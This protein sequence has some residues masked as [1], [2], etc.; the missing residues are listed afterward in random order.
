M[1]CMSERVRCVLNSVCVCV[2]LY[3]YIVYT[4]HDVLCC[5]VLDSYVLN[6]DLT[7]HI[8]CILVVQN[9]V[10]LYR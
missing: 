3:G 2:S 10:R 1:V 6:I 4:C 9:D 8:S 5:V 7:S